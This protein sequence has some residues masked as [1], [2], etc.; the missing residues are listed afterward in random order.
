MGG[1]RLHL[2]GPRTDGT[3]S[4]GVDNWTITGSTVTGIRTNNAVW[5][6]IYFYADSEANQSHHNTVTLSTIQYWS[7]NSVHFQGSNSTYRTHDNVCTHNDLSHSASGLRLTF[8]DDSEV[9]YNTMD[10]CRPGGYPAAESYSMALRSSSRNNVH[11]NTMS[12]STQGMEIWAYDGSAPYTNDGPS[13][14]NW[15]HRNKIYG[16]DNYGF[17]IYEGCCSYTRLEYNLIWGNKDAGIHITEN[18]GAGVGNVIYNNT[19][20]GNDTDNAGYA[21]MYWG[22]ACAGWTFKNNIL[23]NTNRFC[24]HTHAGALFA[25]GNNH[26]YRETGDVVD[27]NGTG[28]DITEVVNWESTCTYNEPKFVS[29]T[30]GSE[31][32]HLQSDSFCIDTAEDVGLETDIEDNPIV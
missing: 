18:T 16:M 22:S 21:D 24:L 23:M 4:P 3:L 27:I 12:D 31:D 28:Y 25:H 2:H 17:L 6:G 19:L 7:G 32:F 5:R 20:Y 11:H 29:T 9:A 10:D 13:D 30:P 26:Y 15:V 8:C 14:G 1:R